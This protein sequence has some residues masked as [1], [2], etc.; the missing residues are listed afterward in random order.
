MMIKFEYMNTVKE[1]NALIVLPAL[2]IE[3]N[4]SAIWICWLWFAFGW[5][6]EDGNN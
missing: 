5:E 1:H 4:P 2:I 6:V 3:W